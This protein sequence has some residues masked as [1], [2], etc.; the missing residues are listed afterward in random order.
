M[1][2]AFHDHVILTKLDWVNAS[3]EHN[4]HERNHGSVIKNAHCH[5]ASFISP[6]MLHDEAFTK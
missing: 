2:I 3:V 4:A 5:R 6:Q 1:C